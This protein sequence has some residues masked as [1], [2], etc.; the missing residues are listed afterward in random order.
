MLQICSWF[1][2]SKFFLRLFFHQDVLFMKNQYLQQT[3]FLW[4]ESCQNVSITPLPLKGTFFCVLPLLKDYRLVLVT[5]KLTEYTIFLVTW[6]NGT[7]LL[8]A[9]WLFYE[10]QRNIYVAC[11][12]H[13]CTIKTE[14]D[15]LLR[16]KPPLVC[17]FFILE[18]QIV[19]RQTQGQ[20]SQQPS[21]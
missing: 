9:V 8:C 17:S 14:P 19:K 21:Y 10:K 12:I 6:Q 1:E 2:P 13:S 20:N 18:S 4:F 7:G 3:F 16:A 15:W 5:D 11:R